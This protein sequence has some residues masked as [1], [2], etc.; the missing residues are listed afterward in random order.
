MNAMTLRIVLLVC[1]GALLGCARTAVERTRYG[2]EEAYRLTDGEYE[3]VVVPRWR[4]VMHYSRIGGS[5]MLWTAPEP[6][7]APAQGDWVN[8]GGEKVW[9]WPQD[10]WRDDSLPNDWP[11][12]DDLASSPG[13]EVISTRRGTLRLRSRM[14]AT[15]PLY[16]VREYRLGRRG[17]LII[18]TR[19][20][21]TDPSP[22][23]APWAIWSIVQLPR[24]DRIQAM[25]LPGA[26]PPREMSGRLDV[27]IQTPGT[28]T[29]DFSPAQRGKIGLDASVLQAEYPDRTIRF[30]RTSTG[31]TAGRFEPGEVAQV[32]AR[33]CGRTPRGDRQGRDVPYIPP[34][35]RAAPARG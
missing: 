13:F 27:H 5:N 6:N 26:G 33:L 34:Q 21:R 16:M 4:R 20:E 23:R 3:A 2:G 8:R 35:P 12:P 28:A 17:E 24:P 18:H 9:L 32:Y 7:A 30:T 1:A 25:L 31:T 29:I 22:P 11:P 14:L 10:Q 15:A 19:L